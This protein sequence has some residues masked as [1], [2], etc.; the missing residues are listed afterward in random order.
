MTDWVKRR[1]RETERE[2]QQTEALKLQGEVIQEASFPT[3]SPFEASSA[4][5]RMLSSLS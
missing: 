1:E 4:L 3:V 2:M 5:T